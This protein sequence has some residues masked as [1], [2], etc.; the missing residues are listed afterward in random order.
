MGIISEKIKLLDKVELQKSEFFLQEANQRIE[1]SF[2]CIKCLK[3]NQFQII[4]FR[5]GFSFS[6][7]YEN[8]HLSEYVITKKEI[9]D[10]AS[11]LYDHLGKYLVDSLPTL[12]YVHSCTECKEKYLTVFSF[13]EKGMDKWKCTIS[14][15][16]RFQNLKNDSNQNPRKP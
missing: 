6:S 3:E 4:P 15:I 10:R 2:S 9:A 5:T 7:L 11:K 8:K 1:T 14:G 16:W 12:Y 13:G